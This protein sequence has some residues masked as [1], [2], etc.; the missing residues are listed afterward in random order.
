[1]VRMIAAVSL[2]FG[3]TIAASSGAYGQAAPLPGSGDATKISSGNASSQ[4]EY[5]H[6]IGSGNAKASPSDD[7][8]P[9]RRGPATAATAA[10]LKPG[11]A[12]RDSNGVRVGTVSAVDA[13][14]VVVDTGSTKIKVPASAFGKDNQGLLLGITAARFNAL[15]AQAHTAH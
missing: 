1:M 7:N 9:V 4:S 10:D 5:N 13:D 14:G 12:L 6:L 2:G 8:R 3:L 15:V 11:L